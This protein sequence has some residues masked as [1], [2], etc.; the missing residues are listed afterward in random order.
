MNHCV[1]KDDLVYL[2]DKV[3]KS[4]EGEYERDVDKPGDELGALHANQSF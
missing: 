3:T 2:I 1:N 4:T